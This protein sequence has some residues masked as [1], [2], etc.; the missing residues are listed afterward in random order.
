[1]TNPS[2]D[3]GMIWRTSALSIERIE[4]PSK[5]SLK[6]HGHDASHLCF[7]E[8][9]SFVERDCGRSRVVTAGTLRTSPSCDQH[10]LTFRDSSRCLLIILNE[11][12]FSAGTKLP[13]ERAYW[14]FP[15]IAQ[16]AKKLID[17]LRHHDS[18]IDL[19]LSVLEFIANVSAPSQRDRPAELPHWLRRIR[20]RIREAPSHPPTTRDLSREAG[21]HPVYVARAFRQRFGI[22]ISEFAR[23]MRA[24]YAFHL[25]A[26]TDHTLAEVAA[27]AG[28]ADQSHLTRSVQKFFAKTPRSLRRS[29]SNSIEV[30]SVQ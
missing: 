17:S 24:K 9:G 26:R 19:E 20:Q 21:L 13:S 6:G 18:S 5:T 16:A 14:E 3:S 29:G 11:E 8:A 10:D 1:M 28:Y 25:L 7:L 15:G 2:T 23:S 27:M 4:I 12:P 30:S 22:G